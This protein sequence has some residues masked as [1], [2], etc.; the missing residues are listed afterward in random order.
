MSKFKAFAKSLAKYQRRGCSCGYPTVKPKH[1][2]RVHLYLHLYYRGYSPEQF[3]H[4]TKKQI[5][6]HLKENKHAD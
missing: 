6:K 1:M 5:R 2:G 4:M 3:T